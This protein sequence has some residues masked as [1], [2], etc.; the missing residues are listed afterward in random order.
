MEPEAIAAQGLL[1][2]LTLPM[3]R[4]AFRDCLLAALEVNAQI[5]RTI[6]VQPE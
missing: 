6:G 3:T 2:A 5:L 4:A 1:G